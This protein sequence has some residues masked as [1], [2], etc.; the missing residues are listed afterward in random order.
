MQLPLRGEWCLRR[1]LL[2]CLP[3]RPTLNLCCFVPFLFVSLS[4]EKTQPSDLDWSWVFGMA[5][6][7][8]AGTKERVPNNA[9]VRQSLRGAPCF[10]EILTNVQPWRHKDFSC[11]SGTTKRERIKSRIMCIMPVSWFSCK[12]NT[13]RRAVFAYPRI[14]TCDGCHRRENVRDTFPN[15]MKRLASP[16][17]TVCNLRNHLV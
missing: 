14:S 11:R 16:M 15:S 13:F 8:A 9:A 17:P 4:R 3:S 5:P 2:G 7:P 10:R 1:P 6:I 12:I